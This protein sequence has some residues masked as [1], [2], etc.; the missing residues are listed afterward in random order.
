VVGAKASPLA[1]MRV[2]VAVVSWNTR[3]LLLR[4]L[5]SLAADVARGRA[6][7]WVVDNGS[8]DGSPQA[9][10]D[11]AP[12]A[13]ILQAERNLGYGAAV[14]LAARRTSDPWLLAVNA[15]VA[16]EPG[17]LQKMLDAGARPRVGC[18]A[19]RLVLPNGATQHSVHALPTL[20]F[21]AAF[22]LGLHRVSGRLAEAACLEGWWDPDRARAVPWAIGACLLLRRAAFDAIGGFDE[23]Q[24]MYA[25]DLDLGWRLRR[26]GWI[27]WYEPRA[28]VLHDAGAATSLAFGSDRRIEFMTATYRLLLRR[29]GPGRMLATAAMNAAGAGLRL[30]WMLPLGAVSGRWRASAAENRGWLTAHLEALRAVS[31]SSRLR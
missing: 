9:A 14:N 3:E 21:T 1:Q 6:E 11:H 23:A 13:H 17:A 30:A 26:A 18:V 20:P 4:C 27:T 10:R 2:T 8:S 15:D 24:W 12:W 22:N 31:S 7:V 16:L 25:E 19:P 5:R 29:R 28:R